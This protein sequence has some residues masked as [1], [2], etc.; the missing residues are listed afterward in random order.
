MPEGGPG[1]HNCP[2]FA[3]QHLAPALQW[4]K[5]HATMV[6]ASPIARAGSIVPHPLPGLTSYPASP[7]SRAVL[8]LHP[9]WQG[10][11]WGCSP[12]RYCWQA[13]VLLWAPALQDLS[14]WQAG[15]LKHLL[16]LKM[17]TC[18]RLGL[19]CGSGHL[20]CWHIRLEKGAQL[21]GGAE[22]RPG[23]QERNRKQQAL[24]GVKFPGARPQSGA[25]LVLGFHCAAP[26]P[27]SGWAAATAKG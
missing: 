27:A 14:C 2:Q 19:C 18:N 4:M 23:T 8:F 17:S 24:L 13:P 20:R 9:L 12:H 22:D 15:G 16:D 1:L 10:A 7:F 11:G 26:S 21:C 25:F 5:R 3:F 6:H